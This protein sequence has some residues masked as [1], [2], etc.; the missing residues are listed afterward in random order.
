[1][2]IDRRAVVLGGVCAVPGP[3]KALGRR[4]GGRDSNTRIPTNYFGMHINDLNPPPNYRRPKIAFPST[5]GIKGVR[6]WDDYLTW[7]LIEP[8][9]GQ[10]SWERFDE[11]VNDIL[12]NNCDVLYTLG[13]P[14][15]WA[16]GQ[17]GSKSL[18]Y[19]TLPPQN[20]SVWT[21]YVRSV[22]ARY[23][24]K[25]SMWEIWNEPDVGG[26]DGSMNQMLQLAASAHGVI[27]SI[28]PN[29][30][31]LTP[32]FSAL[33]KS[34]KPHP[35]TLEAYITAGG[36]KFC[37]GIAIHAYSGDGSRPERLKVELSALRATLDRLGCGR[38]PVYDTESGDR[39]WRDSGGKLRNIPPNFGEPLPTSPVDLQS[40]YVTRH[41]LM[42]LESGVFQRSYY[43]TFDNQ[44]S[45][46]RGPSVMA[47]LMTGYP[48]APAQ[49]LA[50][51]LAYK[52]LANLLPNG[53]VTGFQADGGLFSV[54]FKTIA[55]ANGKVYWAND[56]E[57]AD[58][59]DRNSIHL[60][61][62][63]GQAVEGDAAKFSV[64]GSPVFAFWR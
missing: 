43:Y 56:Y 55:G 15:D 7:R 57:R 29:A 40:A 14:P 61:N 21:A 49:I 52:Y 59:V 58:V 8:A 26:F 54:L 16:S 23:G 41:M 25:I 4:L 28:N 19:N 51:A 2:H 11:I 60:T 62:N 20:I 39:G 47:T 35:V 3:A 38:L 34:I 63:L 42:L 1:M 17:P 18:T 33:G 6:L 37:D 48:D 13:Q 36:A 44:R 53:S 5:L 22:A 32:A 12:A 9:A 24:R 46:P 50:P 31:V 64:T 45:T 27:K 10:Y 30:V